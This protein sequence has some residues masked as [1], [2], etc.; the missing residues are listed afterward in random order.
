M[1]NEE[2]KLLEDTARSLIR[3]RE[4]QKDVIAGVEAALLEIYRAHFTTD[5]R[6][7]ETMAR[8][9][10]GLKVLE[11]QGQG[12][13]FLAQFIRKLEPWTQYDAYESHG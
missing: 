9:K 10:L 7:H 12:A 2:R 5:N 13:G 1:T 6:K 11:S 3:L 4:E 8:L